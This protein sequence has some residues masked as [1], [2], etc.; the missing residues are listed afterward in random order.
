MRKSFLAAGVALALGVGIAANAMAQ[1]KPD[2]LVKQRQA[3]MTLQGKYLGPIG[4]MMK[5]AVPYNADVVALNAT[6][7]ENL[8]R[9]PWDGFQQSTSGE[10]SDAKPEIYTDMAKFRAAA[11]TLEAATVRLGV[12]ARAKDEAGVRANFGGVAK[13]CGSCHDTFRVKR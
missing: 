5:G 1:A 3:A 10:K 4:A 2:V 12:A 9:M 7:L 13:A 6:F 11:D 8:S